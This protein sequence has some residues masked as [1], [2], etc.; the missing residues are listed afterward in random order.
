MIVRQA[1]NC[2]T[3][4]EYAHR[5]TRLKTGWRRLVLHL[6]LSW[7][8]ERVQRENL[9]ATEWTKVALLRNRAQLLTTLGSISQASRD[10][11]MIPTYDTRIE[12]YTAKAYKGEV[13]P[14]WKKSG[15]LAVWSYKLA[16]N[17]SQVTERVRIT[18]KI[19][20]CTRTGST[21][22][23]INSKLDCS[24]T[25]RSLQPSISLRKHY[26]TPRLTPPLHP[27]FSANT[28]SE[29]KLICPY[30]RDFGNPAPEPLTRICG[31]GVISRHPYCRSCKQ[32][33]LA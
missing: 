4:T 25:A 20:P 23:I 2:K 24:P 8:A 1:W 5:Q 6:I 9:S 19:Q 12:L 30:S 14:K 13:T 11:R 17:G 21:R 27:F 31:A 28:P 16:N 32:A 18:R 15:R 10:G 7:P 33:L 3:F 22:M 26:P 29:H